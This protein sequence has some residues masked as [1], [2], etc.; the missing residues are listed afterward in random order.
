MI[1][2]AGVLLG[3]TLVA[4]C[5]GR[6][7][8]ATVT[9]DQLVGGAVAGPTGRPAA[10]A[11]GG[12]ARRRAGRHRR[13]RRS[14]TSPRSGPRPGTTP[15]YFR[16]AGVG[17]AAA[18]AAR[19]AGR[20]A[21][22]PRAR[23][24]LVGAP[25]DGRRLGERDRQ[26]RRRPPRGAV[27][28]GRRP[29]RHGAA[30]ARRG[31]QRLRGRRAARG[32]RA[33]SP[34][35]ATRLP[36]V[37]VAFGAEEPRGPTDDDHHYGSRAYVDALAA[38]QRRVAARHGVDGPGRRRRRAAGRQ[39]RGRRPAPGRAAS[40]R[41]S[42][43]GS[44][45]SPRP[46]SAPATTGRSCATGCPGVRLGSTPYAAYHSSSDVACRSW[47]A[48]SSSG[49]RRVVAGLA[50]AE[51]RQPVEAAGRTGARRP[52]RRR[53]RA[54]RRTGRGAKSTASIRRAPAGSP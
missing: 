44:P 51:R 31:G 29:P 18:R 28:G 5:S 36:V 14:G 10:P 7:R 30:V 47:I 21:A 22:V 50:A 42:G 26:P 6:R 24:L 19:L 11:A 40:P 16:A 25:V 2:A 15:A 17:R 3:L 48:P 39:R 13:W 8:P 34:G 37:L 38:A 46:V 41:P 20:A 35:A 43:P 32:R 54:R 1:R 27:A 33:R 23:R 53:G 52:R 9:L 4:G 12:S 45:T 49:P